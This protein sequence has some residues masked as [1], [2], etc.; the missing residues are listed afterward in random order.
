MG[1]DFSIE[2]FT[3][4]SPENVAVK[5]PIIPRE[6]LNA[7]TIAQGKTPLTKNTAIKSPQTKNH[8]RIRAPI[9]ESTSALIIAL[10]IDE[11]TSKRQSPKMVIM[12]EKTITIFYSIS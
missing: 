6:G 12:I 5:E 8:L 1:A 2:L 7:Q 4:I 3:A 10:S 9:V 11:T